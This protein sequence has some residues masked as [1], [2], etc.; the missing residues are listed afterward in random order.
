[1]SLGTCGRTCLRTYARNRRLSIGSGD[2]TLAGSPMPADLAREGLGSTSSIVRRSR[3]AGRWSLACRWTSVRWPCSRIEW[4]RKEARNDR[5]WARAYVEIP[6]S[7]CL[8][9]ARKRSGRG[10]GVRAYV[11]RQY[12]ESSDD[13]RSAVS[14]KTTGSAFLTLRLIASFPTAP[15][16]VKDEVTCDGGAATSPG[17]RTHVRLSR[18]TTTWLPHAR[19][20]QRI[21]QQGLARI[22]CRCWS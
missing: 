9:Q 7:T 6:S 21:R 1:M 3:E 8:D 14:R 16:R 12:P 11:R 4:W 17:K 13:S 10:K 22:R 20:S 2:M 5:S 15:A 18:A 19:H